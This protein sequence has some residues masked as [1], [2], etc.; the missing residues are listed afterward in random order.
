MPLTVSNPP[1][2]PPPSARSPSRS[3][4]PARSASRSTATP[5]RRST[6]SSRA[7]A[8]TGSS[9]PWSSW[10]RSEGTRSRGRRTSRS[11]PATAGSPAPAPWGWPKSPARSAPSARGPARRRAV[12]EY[13]RQ[14]R[15][16]FSQMMREADA[17]E[18]LLEAE[19]R[20]RRLANL[21]QFRDRGR[22]RVPIVGIPTVG[23]VAPTPRSA[24]RSAW[25]ARTSTARPAPSGGSR[26]TATPVPGAA[27]RPSTPGPR[28]PCGL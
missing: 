6:T 14:R 19:A 2:R 18:A 28:R 23:A 4:R 20:R 13:N 3:L 24:A 7:S 27:W 10:P 5:P 8:S 21:R 25:G 9:S 1:A 11:S 22:G 26:A 17:L 16:T 15:K 12:L